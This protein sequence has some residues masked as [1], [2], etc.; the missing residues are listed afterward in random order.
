MTPTPYP[1]PLSNLWSEHVT[2]EHGIGS[3]A[4]ISQSQNICVRYPI[5]SPPYYSYAITNIQQPWQNVFPFF[6]ILSFP[7]KKIFT[8]LFSISKQKKKENHTNNCSFV[9]FTLQYLL[10]YFGNFNI[11]L[12]IPKTIFCITLQTK[13]KFLCISMVNV[14]F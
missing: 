13:N 1:S 5:P 8:K 7:R 14:F 6:S 4:F 12:W 2:C 11:F 3:H 10:I 9:H